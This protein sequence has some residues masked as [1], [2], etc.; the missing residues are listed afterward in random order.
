MNVY[1]FSIIFVFVDERVPEDFIQCSGLV[2]RCAR[3][4]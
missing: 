3:S 1:D 2:A 4:V